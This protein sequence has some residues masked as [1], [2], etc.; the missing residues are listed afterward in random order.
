MHDG[1]TR[2]TDH[3]HNNQGILQS[4]LDN[5]ASQNVLVWDGSKIPVVVTRHTFFPRKTL[6]ERKIGHAYLNYVG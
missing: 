6:N 3:V 5:N 1:Y 2:A 4:L